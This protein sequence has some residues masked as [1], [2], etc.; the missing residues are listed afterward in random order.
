[1]T[2]NF[3]TIS[4]PSGSGKTTLC[5]ALQ[6]VVR[7]IKWSISYTTREKRHIERDGVDYHFIS[8]NEFKKMIKND[9][10]SEWES[11]HGNYYGTSKDDLQYIIK[12]NSLLLLETDVKG[13]MAIAKQYPESTV[14]IFIMPPSIETLR[15]RLFNRGTDSAEEIEKRLN[16][17]KEEME[18]KDKFDYIIVNNNF[19][20]AKID[21]INKVTK[22]KKGVCNGT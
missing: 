15:E 19:E 13:A 1:M 11:V 3:I 16:R 9:S 22:I 12:N 14:S 4:A 8:K 10:F 21:L 2:V 6:E 17:F 18:Y 20:L 7:D 5:K